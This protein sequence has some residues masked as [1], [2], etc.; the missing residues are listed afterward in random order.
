M[1]TDLARA[2]EKDIEVGAKAR[3]LE[4]VPWTSMGL[5]LVSMHYIF[6]RLPTG[7]FGGFNILQEPP[8]TSSHPQDYCTIDLSGLDQRQDHHT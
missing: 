5:V 8:V 6:S 2:W 1:T 4:A 7:C 3:Q